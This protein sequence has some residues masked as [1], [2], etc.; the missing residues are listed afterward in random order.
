MSACRGI[1]MHL[2]RRTAAGE[3]GSARWNLTVPYRERRG[4]LDGVFAQIR[5][6]GDS[7]D[8]EPPDGIARGNGWIATGIAET[9]FTAGTPSEMPA[10]ESVDAVSPSVPARI[11]NHSDSYN[12]SAVVLP[13]RCDP[14]STNVS[15]F[16]S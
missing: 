4:D 11:L 5:R 14:A 7:P 10:V 2:L 13:S 1:E 9:L 3:C 15:R 12:R 6:G 8:G 16:G